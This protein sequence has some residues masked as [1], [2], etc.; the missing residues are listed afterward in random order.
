[1]REQK[2]KLEAKMIMPGHLMH[3]YLYTIWHHKKLIIQNEN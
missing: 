3:K 1:M 2:R